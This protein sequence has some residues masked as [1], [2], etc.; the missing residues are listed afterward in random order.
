MWSR[1]DVN[2]AKSGHAQYIYH[3]NRSISAEFSLLKGVLK[4]GSKF[5]AEHPYGS[6]I[7]IKLQRNPVKTTLPQVCSTVSFL[8]I[9]RTALYKRN[10]EGLCL[11]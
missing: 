8:H 2:I 1:F 6:I 9:F 7:S 10:Y 3:I 5:A 11:H 4:I